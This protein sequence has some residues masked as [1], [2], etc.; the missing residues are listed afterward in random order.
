MNDKIEKKLQPTRDSKNKEELEK[1]PFD[2]NALNINEKLY[3]ELKKLWINEGGL[4]LFLKFELT[5]KEEQSFFEYDLKKLKKNINLNFNKK[6]VLSLT[7]KFNIR[8]FFNNCNYLRTTQYS[9]NQKGWK[10]VQ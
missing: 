6:S 9:I 7:E 1:L 10:H 8:I 5:T 2:I 3:K 4:I